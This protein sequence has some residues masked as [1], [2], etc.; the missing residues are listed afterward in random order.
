M[1]MRKLIDDTDFENI[2]ELTRRWKKESNPTS[3]AHSQLSQ[4]PEHGQS[5]QQIPEQQL[6]FKENIYH[7]PQ[8]EDSRVVSD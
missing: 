3:L 1:D 2:N 7:Q 4:R 6:P 8:V 5:I